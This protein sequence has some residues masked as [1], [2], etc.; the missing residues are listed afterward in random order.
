MQQSYAWKKESIAR[1]EHISTPVLTH[2][3]SCAICGKIFLGGVHP[4]LAADR[5]LRCKTCKYRL[6][7]TLAT[8]GRERAFVYWPHEQSCQ[9]HFCF[10]QKIDIY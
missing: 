4:P 6:D 1:I 3:Y 2:E 5:Q 7:V 8:Q 10:Y 9:C